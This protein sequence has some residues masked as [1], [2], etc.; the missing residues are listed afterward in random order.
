ML[1]DNNAYTYWI[2]LFNTEL[3]TNYFNVFFNPYSFE[4]PLAIDI[5]PHFPSSVGNPR[6]IFNNGPV[7]FFVNF[8]RWIH[9]TK[10][11]FY[12][13]SQLQEKIRRGVYVYCLEAQSFKDLIGK[14]K[15]SKYQFWCNFQE[16][17]SI[18][19]C[20]VL[21]EELW[22]NRENLYVKQL[23]FFIY[24]HFTQSSLTISKCV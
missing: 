12:L 24:S 3:V 10:G 5:G 8:P 2:I 6:L 17:V 9:V 7:K 18:K 1:Q 22:D 16:Y 13:N 4:A 23:F 14:A 19:L 20:K 15:G 11:W 21:N